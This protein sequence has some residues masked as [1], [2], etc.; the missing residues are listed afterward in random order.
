M[1]KNFYIYFMSNYSRTTFYIGVTNNLARR[2][3][4]HNKGIGS[5]FV[6][7]Y[8]LVDLV[9]YEHFSDIKYAILREKQ[10][11]NWYHDWKLNLIKRFNPNLVDLKYLLQ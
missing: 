3:A 6:R 8:K 9:Y 2:V 7:K 5:Q 4:E 10:L 1:I 11:K